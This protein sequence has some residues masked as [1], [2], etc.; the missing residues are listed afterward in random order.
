MSIRTNK[1][2]G[3]ESEKAMPN[4]DSPE[5]SVARGVVCISSKVKALMADR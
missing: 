5:A 4:G 1:Y 2:T 3:Q